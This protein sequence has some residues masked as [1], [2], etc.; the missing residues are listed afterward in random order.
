LGEFSFSIGDNFSYPI[1]FTPPFFEEVMKWACPNFL[2]RCLPN[3]SAGGEVLRQ[4]EE[5]YRLAIKATNDA[6]WDL[7]LTTGTVQWNEAYAAAFGRPMETVNFWQWWIDHIHPEDRSAQ[8]ADFGRPL[9]AGRTSG[10]ASIASCE[11]MAPGRT[12]TTGLTSHATGRGTL[13]LS[14]ASMLKEDV[15]R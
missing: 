6:I 13:L 15:I 1:R 2:E 14:R 7:N 5:R 12:F 3:A 4:S 11:L 9:T 8:V 10:F